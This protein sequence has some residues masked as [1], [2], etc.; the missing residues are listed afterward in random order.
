MT[1]SRYQ[2]ITLIFLSYLL[3]SFDLFQVEKH[4]EHVR[5]ACQSTYK[6]MSHTMQSHGASDYDKRLVCIQI[7]LNC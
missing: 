2:I 6:K 4:I 3:S 1:G 7:K 5:T